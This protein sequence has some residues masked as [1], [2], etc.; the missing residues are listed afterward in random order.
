MTDVTTREAERNWGKGDRRER[1]RERESR[2]SEDTINSSRIPSHRL[3][4]TY[5]LPVLT[6]VGSHE[7][8]TDRY[9]TVYMIY[10]V[11]MIYMIYMIY[12]KKKVFD[13]NSSK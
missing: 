4:V 1:E 3:L 5:Q 8:V 9:M 6:D 2:A 12:M 11:N 10:M 7:V 13:E